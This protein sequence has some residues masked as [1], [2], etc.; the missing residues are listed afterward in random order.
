MKTTYE[1]EFIPFATFEDGSDDFA[2]KSLTINPA[3]SEWKPL[4]VVCRDGKWYVAITRQVFV[5]DANTNTAEF[6]M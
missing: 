6:T 4:N 3:A 5:A 2:K 1:I